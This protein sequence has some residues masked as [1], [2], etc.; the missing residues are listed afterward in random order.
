MTYLSVTQ[1]VSCLSSPKHLEWLGAGLTAKE[2]SS[3]WKEYSGLL[4]F[5]LHNGKRLVCNS[6]AGETSDLDPIML[7]LGLRPTRG[8]RGVRLLDPDSWPF[9]KMVDWGRVT[10][11]NYFQHIWSLFYLPLQL[12][13]VLWEQVY[14]KKQT[15]TQRKEAAP[16]RHHNG[17]AVASVSWTLSLRTSINLSWGD[18]RKQEVMLKSN[19]SSLPL[20]RTTW[21]SY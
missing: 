11:C 5:S 21:G 12:K 15:H 1:G 16:S 13:G 17:G 4:L 8:G 9:R 18:W 20:S 6:K 14:S 10:S 3:T 7:S 2:R 19:Q